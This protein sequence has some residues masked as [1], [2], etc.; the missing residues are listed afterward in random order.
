[1][2]LRILSR[3]RDWSLVLLICQFAQAQELNDHS[4]ARWREYIIPKGDELAYEQIAWKLSFWE[5][6]I[7]AQR[8]DKPILLYAMTG[9]PCGSV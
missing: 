6:V 7:A 5:G 2:I 9:H 1:M 3:T 4:F 8:E